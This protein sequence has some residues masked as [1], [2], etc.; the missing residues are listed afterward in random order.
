MAADEKLILHLYPPVEGSSEGCV[1]SDAGDGYAEWRVYRF[2]M[3]RDENGLKVLRF[4][5]DAVLQDWEG[6]CRRIE[7]S[8]PPTSSPSLRL[9]KGG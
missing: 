5:N 2:R 9:K 3:V 6:V 8:I 7:E 4:T 1:Y